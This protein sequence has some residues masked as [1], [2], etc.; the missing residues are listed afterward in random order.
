[1]DRAMILMKKKLLLLSE[2]T[3]YCDWNIYELHLYY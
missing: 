1:M 2:T 3:N